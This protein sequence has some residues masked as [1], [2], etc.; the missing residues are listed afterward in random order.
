VEDDSGAMSED[1]RV[2]SEDSGLFPN[3]RV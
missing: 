1:S 3:L 2:M